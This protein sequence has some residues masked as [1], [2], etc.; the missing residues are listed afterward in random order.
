MKKEELMIGD[1]YWWE[2]EGKKY[3]MRV[4][5]EDFA[6][7]DE[8]VAN[9]EPIPITVE[10]LEANGFDKFTWWKNHKYDTVTYYVDGYQIQVNE[11]GTFSLVDSCSDDGDYGFESNWICDIKYVHNLQHLF[12]DLEI[13]KEIVL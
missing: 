6:L 7:S 1:W 2:A 11:D 4:K 10:I 13:K 12:K 3:P 9:F 5:A 8:D